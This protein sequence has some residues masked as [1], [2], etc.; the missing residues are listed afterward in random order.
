MMLD[1]KQVQQLLKLKRFE[2]PPPGYFERAL[3]EFHRR[4]RAEILRRSAFQ[5]WIER[6]SSSFGNFRVPAWAYAGAFSVFAVI[7]TLLGTGMWTPEGSSRDL[8]N[9]VAQSET[10]DSGLR[11]TSRGEI[12]LSGSE[13]KFQKFFPTIQP[14]DASRP[15]YILDRQPVS[16]QPPGSF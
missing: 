3:E 1:E 2:Q 13:T 15:R 7:A 11:L 8:P 5:I 9:A 6:L 4:Q 10:S 16:Y 14:S 12:H